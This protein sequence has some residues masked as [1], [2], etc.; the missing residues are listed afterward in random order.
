MRSAGCSAPSAE[1]LG[2]QRRGWHHTPPEPTGSCGRRSMAPASRPAGTAMPACCGVATRTVVADPS[3]RRAS[4]VVCARP[5]RVGAFGDRREVQDGYHCHGFNRPRPGRFRLR[6]H[7]ATYA[8]AWSLWS[9]RADPPQFW[10]SRRPR[11]A[12]RAGSAAQL[13]LH[14]CVPRLS[15]AAEVTREAVGSRG[16]SAGEHRSSC[17]VARGSAARPGARAGVGLTVSGL[18]CRSAAAGRRA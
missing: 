6:H 3:P 15:S 18:R 10:W 7:V 12:P 1:L 9:R 5:S 2:P 14:R 17:P 4:A 13:V 11:S 16:R 8:A